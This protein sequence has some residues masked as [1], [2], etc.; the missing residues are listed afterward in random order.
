VNQ[1]KRK[2][3]LLIIGHGRHGKDTVAEKIRDKM[4]LQFTSSSMFVGEEV[5]WPMW[6]RTRYENFDAMFA[7]RVN[8]RTVWGDLIAAYNTPDKTMT[9]KT[10]LSRGYDMYVGMRRFDELKA[11]QDEGLFDHVIWV[12]RSQH[13]ARES[14]E[15]M[16]VHEHHADL[17]IDN[18]GTEAQLDLTID[19]LQ[20]KLHEEGFDVNYVGEPE[21][22]NVF[23][24]EL[25]VG[26]PITEPYQ[27]Q[28]SQR[29][30]Q[31]LDH[32]FA[33][34]VDSMGNDAAIVQAA[35]VSYGE[36]TKTPSDDR[37]LIRYLM[38]H[39]HTTPFEMVEFKFHLKLPMAIG[40][41]LLRHRTASPNKVS[42]R[43]SILPGEFY[44]PEPENLGA[45]SKINKQGREH[46]IDRALAG[47]VIDL[48]KE[49][50]SEA[51]S[52]Y[53][54]LAKDPEEGGAY[55]VAREL[56][57]FNLPANIY[58]ELYWKIDL[59]NLFHFLRLRLDSHAQYEI[60]VMAQA[61]FDL[62][63]P[64]VPV[65][66]EAFED[67]RLNA[68]GFSA[69]EMEILRGLI[70]SDTLEDIFHERMSKREL[71]EFRAKFS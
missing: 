64:I 49:N 18:N 11:C 37:S 66:A 10:M 65:A 45:Q 15:S 33:R 7:D 30:I 34:L 9:A 43:Y 24:T 35:R 48:M 63:K 42:G 41:Q 62:I 20:K 60:R 1:E 69:M 14:A 70:N 36:G 22:S 38:R 56:A 57:R 44:F 21:T 61:I 53:E 32:G 25:T 71:T 52:L 26:E 40:E 16:R 59:H 68:V 6:G 2:P 13:V 8:Y 50:A 5:I 28:P 55:G 54:N 46:V 51:Y 58:T 23:E 12:D 19:K 4:G 39:W 29:Q 27:Y 47:E 3:R 67:Y 31:V 17:I